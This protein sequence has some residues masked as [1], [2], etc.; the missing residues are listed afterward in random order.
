VKYL[1]LA[2]EIAGAR[3]EF[4]ETGNTST[5]SDLLRMLAEKH[6][7]RMRG[8]LFDQAG[9]PRTH[10]QFFLNDKSIHLINGLETALRDDSTLAIVPPVSGG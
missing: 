6:G 9:K 1:A 4:I 3:E 10:L 2:R 8:Y 7:P 5:V